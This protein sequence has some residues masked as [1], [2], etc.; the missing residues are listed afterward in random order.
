[1]D[2]DTLPVLRNRHFGVNLSVNW[3]RHEAIWY[4]LVHQYRLH[5]AKSS[6][7]EWKKPILPLLIISISYRYKLR[8]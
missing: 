2:S 3:Y 7:F 8:L 6:N 4:A 5:I 1:M